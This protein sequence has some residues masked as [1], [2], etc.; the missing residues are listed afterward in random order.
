MTQNEMLDAF[1]DK[2]RCWHEPTTNVGAALDQVYDQMDYSHPYGAWI[3]GFEQDTG[4]P[5][6][7]Y[8]PFC[9]D[10]AGI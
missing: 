1:E 9:R 3:I 6:E 7:T 5:P 2:W 4:I 8:M 10:G